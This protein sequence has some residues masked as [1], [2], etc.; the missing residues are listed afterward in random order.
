MSRVLPAEFFVAGGTSRK[1]GLPLNGT[2]FN[3]KPLEK[4]FMCS[5]AYQIEGHVLSRLMS[6]S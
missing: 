4:G 5:Y 3:I 1:L 6:G 2:Q